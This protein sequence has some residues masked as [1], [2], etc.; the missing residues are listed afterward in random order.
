MKPIALYQ[1]EKEYLKPLPSNQI[2]E[3]YMDL[4]ISVKVRNT[5][6]IY[7]KGSEYSVP[8][9]Y[10]NKTLKVKELENKLYIY[11]STNLVTTHE[12]STQKINYHKEHYIEGLKSSMPN[13]SDEYIEKL[14]QKNLDIMNQIAEQSANKN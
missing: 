2:L 6:L 9:K 4:R 14:A 11:D 5:S 12:I 10:I 13:K 3:H 7:Y 1:K 8:P